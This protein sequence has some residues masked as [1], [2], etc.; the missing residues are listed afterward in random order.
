[1]IS[2]IFKDDEFAEMIADHCADI[3]DYLIASQTPF[4]ILCD[5][6]E[7]TFE[8]PLPE[9]LSQ[10]FKPLTLFVLSDYTLGGAEL[11]EDTF[12]LIFEAGF[13]EQNFGSIVSV[14][15]D[16][17]IQVLLEDTVIFLNLSALPQNRKAK[18]AK[19]SAGGDASVDRSMQS[20]LDNPE[21]RKFFKK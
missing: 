16:S 1:M 8:P 11:N 4:G 7:I 5:L 20:F 18:P 13:G 14:P 17:V 6:N 2:K 15:I 10:S 19:T 12:T 21:N 9:S 3:L